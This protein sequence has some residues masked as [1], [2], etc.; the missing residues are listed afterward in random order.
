MKNPTTTEEFTFTSGGESLVGNL[1][2]PK[3]EVTALVVA[4]GPFTSVK[5]QAAG[6]YA[7]AMAERGFAAL[8][9]DHRCFGKSGGEPRQFESPAWRIEDI[10][11]AAAALLD[12]DRFADLPVNGLGVCYGAGP[13]A[14]AV[15]EGDD[16]AAFAGVA[17]VYTDGAQTKSMMGDA[18]R[19]NID[20]A[21]DA[22][23]RWKDTGSA[24]TI[25]AV[26]PDGGDVAMPLREAYEFYGTPRRRAELHQRVRGSVVG[27]HA[28]VRRDVPAAGDGK[29]GVDRALG[30]SAAADAR[31]TLP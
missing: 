28:A 8:A 3:G 12:D 29:A 20:R 9:F 17:G 1:F 23:R 2:L 7:E 5:E 16:F 31:A 10:R 26:A 14:I 13:M 22:E 18:Y 30:E 6:V 19:R 25:P 11:N 24:E 15:H 4:T 21:K 27:L